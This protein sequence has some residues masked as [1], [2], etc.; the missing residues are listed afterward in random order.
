M[1]KFLEIWRETG[2]I[3]SFSPFPIK[4]SGTQ[5]ILSFPYF[6]FCYFIKITNTLSLS[7]LSKFIGRMLSF[8]R[9][10]AVKKKIIRR[11]FPP[12]VMTHCVCTKYRE[13]KKCRLKE[14]KKKNDRRRG[15]F[16]T[17]KYNTWQYVRLSFE[18]PNKKNAKRGRQKAGIASSGLCKHVVNTIVD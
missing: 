2:F 10:I 15:K 11:W 5:Y 16:R 18:S 1:G 14:C 9:V 4:R 13:S 7:C 6:T 17:R 3:I 8:V 12:H